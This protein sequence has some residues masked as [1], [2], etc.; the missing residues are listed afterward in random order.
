MEE[1]CL[2]FRIDFRPLKQFY[3]S[4]DEEYMQQVIRRILND[5]VQPV[6]RNISLDISLDGIRDTRFHRDFDILEKIGKGG[7]GEVFKVQHR[8]D[9]NIYAIKQMP[10]ELA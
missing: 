9:K 1:F 6:T 8:L 2:K 5:H 7:F 3:F 10:I 4:K